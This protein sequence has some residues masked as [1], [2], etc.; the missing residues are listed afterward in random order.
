MPTRS[1]RPTNS[2]PKVGRTW[3]SSKR[4]LVWSVS[5]LRWPHSASL[6]TIQ[7]STPTEGSCARLS[8]AR[9]RS[10]IRRV[11]PSRELGTVPPLRQAERRSRNDR[12]GSP[13]HR[14]ER[15]AKSLFGKGEGWDGFVRFLL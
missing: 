4:R 1:A 7:S 8:Q 14:W 3:K 9:G 2:P 13:R 6:P 5:V 10:P 15:G 11:P 12:V